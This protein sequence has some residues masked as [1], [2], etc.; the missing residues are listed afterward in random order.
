MIAAIIGATG[1]VGQQ[2]LKLLLASDHYEQVL[3]IG[4]RRLDIDSSKLVQHIMPL[5]Q[6]K[7]LKING[8]VD[9]AFCTLGTT[10][11]V[12][13]SKENFARVDRDYVC[14]F[15]GWAITN[16]ASAMA[17]NSSVGADAKSVNFYLHTKGEMEQCVRS[18]R[19]NSL[20]IVRPSLLVPT[21]RKQ[22]RFGEE[23]SYFVLKLFGWLMIGKLR[24]YKAVRPADVAAAMLNG[25]SANRGGTNIIESENITLWAQRRESGW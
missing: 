8:R 16:G 23:V 7:S 9:H 4:R 2:L 17:V 14:A 11:D 6:I 12:A 25:V 5:D 10:I 22:G 3:Y 18:A 20:T 24:R 13:K 15:A 21:G 19:F 1:L